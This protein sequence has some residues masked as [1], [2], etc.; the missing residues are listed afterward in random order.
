MLASG[1]LASGA[2]A[3][4]VAAD[5]GAGE[6]VDGGLTVETSTLVESD[7]IAHVT[8]PEGKDDGVPGGLIEV[9]TTSDGTTL[10]AYCLDAGTALKRGAAYREAGRSEVPTLKGNP[11][12]AKVDWILRHGYPM[13]SE[14][15]LGEQ[16]GAELSKGAAAGA[17]QAAIWRLTNHVKAVPWDPAGAEL[18]D[19]LVAHAVDTE[20][21]APSL[22]LAPG[23]VAGRAGSILGPITIGSTGDQ[24]GVY[25][26]PA[27]VAAGVALTDRYGN[28]V[29]DGDGRL[30]ESVTDGESVFVKAP[31]DAGQVDAT[32][33]AM[34]FV[35]VPVGHKLVSTESQALVLVSGDWVP[36]TART[37]ASW[38]AA[39][40]PSPTPTP[41]PTATAT[42]APTA[43]ADP[44][45]SVSPDPSGSVSPDPSGSVS[46]DPSQSVSPTA[47]S[48]TTAPT[49]TTAPGVRPGATPGATHSADAGPSAPAA[50]GA[51]GDSELASTGSSG[52]LW[53]VA[54]SGAGLVV[55]GAAVVL[56]HAWRRRYRTLG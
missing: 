45:G 7:Y 32:V 33:S 52:V 55:L 12:A 30:I 5:A 47:T 54:V 36:V 43:T 18:A 44:S 16:I 34:S 9:T 17:T 28:V 3:T 13:V 21:P 1:M 35:P 15:A 56:I 48:V 27:A 19:H 37:K 14:K 40:P 50:T 10:L 22:A 6:G 23:T 4:A 38:T 51:A 49:A 24:I 41:T 8:E 25:L 42:P 53:F 2:A 11:D 26:D 31:A 20:E 46:P 39:I 29:S